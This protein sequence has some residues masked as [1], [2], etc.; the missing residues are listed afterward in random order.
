L[1]SND[2]E[3]IE[4]KKLIK[5]IIGTVVITTGIIL[6]FLIPYVIKCNSY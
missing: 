6:C 5:I 3:Y 2:I 1:W 4:S